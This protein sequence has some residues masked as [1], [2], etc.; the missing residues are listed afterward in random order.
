MKW[1]NPEKGDSIQTYIS[2]ITEETL[3]KYADEEAKKYY[4]QQEEL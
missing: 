2:S 3:E 4:E 1:D